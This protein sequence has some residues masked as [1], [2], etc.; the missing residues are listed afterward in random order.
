MCCGRVPCAQ[1]TRI[2]L[3]KRI[4]DAPASCNWSTT[5]VSQCVPHVRKFYACS[6]LKFGVCGLVGAVGVARPACPGAWCHCQRL[7]AR[8][9]GPRCAAGAQ[10]VASCELAASGTAQAR[11]SALR[12]P[13]AERE[14]PPGLRYRTVSRPR[15]AARRARG[16]AAQP[17]TSL[18]TCAA[19]SLARLQRWGEKKDFFM[20]YMILYIASK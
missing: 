1:V 3:V 9:R 5:G 14:P 18:R 4:A 10:P 2:L 17:V 11:G 13:L 16:C 15:R 12:R 7:A 8:P 19:S 20:S 6:V